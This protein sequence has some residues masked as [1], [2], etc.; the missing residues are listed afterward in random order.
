MPRK[1][2]KRF[3]VLFWLIQIL[4]LLLIVSC[5]SRKNISKSTEEREIKSDITENVEVSGR[6]DIHE[7]SQK[8]EEIEMIEIVTEYSAPDSL[9][10]QYPVRRT[11]KKTAKKTSR[12]GRKVVKETVS[13]KSNIVDRS[14]QKTV[15]KEELKT[16][17]KESRQ[18]PMIAVGCF[19]IGLVLFVYKRKFWNG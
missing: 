3:D 1:S 18:I 7:D 6:R 13:S 9:G 5:G 16:E 17:K 10:N 11:G 2:M 15:E 14:E 19:I 4:F 12:E 8:D